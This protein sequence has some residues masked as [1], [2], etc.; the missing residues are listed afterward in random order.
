MSQNDSRPGRSGWGVAGPLSSLFLVPLAL[1]AV[2]TLVGLWARSEVPL[3]LGRY[4]QAFFAFN[5]WN[6]SLIALGVLTWGRRSHLL[7]Q[8]VYLALIPTTV[9]A[10]ANNQ[11]FSPSWIP[12]LM[13]LIRLTTGAAM[14]L[15]GFDRYR[16]G[17]G[18]PRAA[19][20]GLGAA[21]LALSVL[22]LSLFAVIYAGPEHRRPEA[23]YREAYALDQVRR[24]DVILVGD[25][26]V[27]GAGVEQ[28]QRFGDRLEALYHEHGQAARVY[29]LGIVAAGP[30]QYLQMLAEVPPAVNADR[31]I[32]AFYMND[33]PLTEALW[34][35]IEDSGP[36]LGRGFP[37]IRLV[38]DTLAKLLASDVHAYHDYV[39]DSHREDHPSFPARWALLGRQLDELARLAAERSERPPLLMIL[40]LMVGFEGYPLEAAHARLATAARGAGF[41]VLDMLP[42]FRTEL[43]DADLH[44]IAPD[45]NHF[46][47]ETHDLVARTLYRTLGPSASGP[48][49]APPPAF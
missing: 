43:I 38:G 24:G 6:V 10:S 17:L 45:D 20:L 19:F 5:L 21:V 3:I 18:R 11:L 22:D 46:D 12:P 30:F 14:V 39:V 23:E 1:Y 36:V 47:A 25:S 41:E 8:L 9:I 37:S 26:F 28:R 35:R 34:R 32:V 48:A 16:R 7:L 40:P 4:S 15:I 2:P 27:W 29:S 42:I 13:P 31:V 49:V 44:R 33:M